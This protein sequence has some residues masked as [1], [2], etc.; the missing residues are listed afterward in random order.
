[1][2][3]A[4]DLGLNLSGMMLVPAGNPNRKSQMP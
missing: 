2:K 1:M 3:I 4:L